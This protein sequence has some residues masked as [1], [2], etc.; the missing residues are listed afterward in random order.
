MA[1][2]LLSTLIL[3]L[4]SAQPVSAQNEETPP[5]EIIVSGDRDPRQ[6]KKAINQFIRTVM[7]PESSDQYARFNTPICPSAI[8]FSQSVEALIESRIREVAEAAKINLASNKCKPNLHVVLV[9]YGKD[10]VRLL[11]S[12]ARGAFGRMRPYERDQIER[13]EGPVYNWHA[14]FPVS[15]DTGG[16]RAVLNSGGTG[17]V[18]AGAA[19]LGEP[20]YN[21][22]MTNVKSRLLMPIQQDI[23]HGVVLIEREAA[24]GLSAI[25]VA[26]FAAMRGLL[27]ARSNSADLT[28]VATIMNLFDAEEGDLLPGLSEWDL[29]LL[30]ALYKA[31]ADMNSDRQR[32]LMSRTFQKVLAEG[33]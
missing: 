13:G 7:R 25:Q 21:A 4:V 2:A 31:P 28:S 22:G 20:A 3:G 11:R 6:Q 33:S 18:G 26:D 32:S 24:R 9:E 29:A 19:L 10:A 12:K 14:V 16:N 27:N 5:S 30:T 8:G 1:R 23:A 15:S 17:A